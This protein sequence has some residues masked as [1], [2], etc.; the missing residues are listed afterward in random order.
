MASKHIVHISPDNFASEVKQS[1][2][3][4]LVDFWAEWCGPCRAIAPL[5]DE[6]ADANAGKIKIA[7]VNV[8]ENQELSA[9]YSIRAIP[10]MIVFKN[11]EVQEQMVGAISKRDLET[12]LAPY[13]K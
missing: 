3:P 13:L 12:K 4:V 7:K 5:L 10:T 2:T 8:D 9:E 1:Q 6:I 11:G